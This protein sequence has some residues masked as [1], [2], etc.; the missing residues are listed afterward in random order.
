MTAF[1]L[2]VP[3]QTIQEPRFEISNCSRS[4][5][6]W[7]LLTALQPR[8]ETTTISPSGDPAAVKVIGATS[9]STLPTL[10]VALDDGTVNG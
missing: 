5:K 10:K 1:N 2:I 6:T 9:Y 8:L 7:Y 4:L 3:T